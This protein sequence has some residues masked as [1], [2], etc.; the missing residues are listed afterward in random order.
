MTSKLYPDARCF[1]SA[2]ETASV[3]R[4]AWSRDERA[5]LKG[6]AERGAEPLIR[7]RRRCFYVSGAI[8]FVVERPRGGGYS[9]ARVPSG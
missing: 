1:M 2:I 4:A 3:D 9:V 7:M 8:T 6:L 5:A